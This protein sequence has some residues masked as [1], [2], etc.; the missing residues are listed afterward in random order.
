MEIIPII[1][2]ILLI[3][4]GIVLYIYVIEPFLKSITIEGL[5]KT[6]TH[7]QPIQRTP[8]IQPTQ[9]TPSIQ[10]T[11]PIQRTQPTQQSTQSTQRIQRT[12]PIQPIQRTQPIQ[13]IVGGDCVSLINTFRAKQ[14]VSPLV[15]ATSEQI[16]CANKSAA[17]DAAHGYHAS[18]YSGMCPGSTGECECMRTSSVATCINMYIAEGPGGG[19]FNILKDPQ[20]KSVACGTDGNGFFT[21]NFYR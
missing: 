11:Q 8:S 20:Y 14:G 5:G 18:F 15:A 12:Q 17:Y 1:S 19:H 7:T 16:A 4:L 10:P 13:P 3:I 9:P 21:H 2:I 6:P